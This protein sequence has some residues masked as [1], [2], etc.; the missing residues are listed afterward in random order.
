[1]FERYGWPTPRGALFILLCLWT[2]LSA[3]AV[4]R[5]DNYRAFMICGNETVVGLLVYYALRRH[6]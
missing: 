4:V 1:M 3:F 6:R 5:G 2:L